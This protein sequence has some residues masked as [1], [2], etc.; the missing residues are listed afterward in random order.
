MTRKLDTKNEAFVITLRT[1]R[2]LFFAYFFEID[3]HLCELIEQKNFT[4]L[5]FNNSNQGKKCVQLL[6]TD[7]TS[8]ALG[9]NAAICIRK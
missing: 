3:G 5:V 8:I 7:T 4:L 2:F 1:V 9:P 6:H